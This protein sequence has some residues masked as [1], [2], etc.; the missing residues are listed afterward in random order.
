MAPR[1]CPSEGQRSVS[2]KRGKRGLKGRGSYIG[3]CGVQCRFWGRALRS[4]EAVHVDRDGV[5][6]AVKAV[7]E[8]SV[9]R[10]V[11]SKLV[12]L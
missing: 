12:V 8:A 6:K 3:Y 9:R 7:E 1:Q 11:V 2:Q 5:T 10:I 4:E